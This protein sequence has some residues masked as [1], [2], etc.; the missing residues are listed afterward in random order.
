M[1]FNMVLDMFFNYFLQKIYTY[2]YIKM[3][4]LTRIPPD[5]D[6]SKDYYPIASINCSKSKKKLI[7]ITKSNYD[8]YTEEIEKL[9]DTYINDE[10]QRKIL[11]SFVEERTL[12]RGKYRKMISNMISALDI[13]F[14]RVIEIDKCMRYPNPLTRDAINIYGMQGSGK[15]Y[16]TRKY[17]N[18]YSKVYPDKEIYLLTT[19]T[20]NDPLYNNTGIKKLNITRELIENVN[21]DETTFE[22][23]LVIFDDIEHYDQGIYTWI[24]NIRDILFLKARKHNVDVINVIHKGLNSRLTSIPNNECNGCV[25]FPRFNTQEARKILQNY[26]ELNN[27]QIETIFSKEMKKNSRWV[28]INKVY[29]KYLICENGTQ[30]LD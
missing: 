13:K 29:P 16:W 6:F 4:K 9:L 3:Y 10:D 21:F 17:V 22:N 23:S 7:Y 26:F 25:I 1:F 11:Y 5:S 24:R 8:E 2:K 12:P 27:K 19:N 28:Y 14:G 30:L 15:S 20:E 18:I